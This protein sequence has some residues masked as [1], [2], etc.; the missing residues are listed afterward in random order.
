MSLRVKKNHQLT[1]SIHQLINLQFNQSINQ[2]INLNTFRT[3]VSKVNCGT[4]PRVDDSTNIQKKNLKSWR[5]G[6]TLSLSSL[7]FFYFFPLLFHCISLVPA[8]LF[9]AALERRQLRHWQRT[10]AA[11]TITKTGPAAWMVAEPLRQQYQ[12]RKCFLFF[13]KVFSV[14]ESA[15]LGSQGCSWDIAGPQ[16]VAQHPVWLVFLRLLIWQLFFWPW[17]LV[18][19]LLNLGGAWWEVR[20]GCLVRLCPVNKTP[21]HLKKILRSWNR[22]GKEMHRPQHQTHNEASRNHDATTFYF[23]IFLS[24]LCLHCCRS[25]FW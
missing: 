14:Y 10:V 5:H 12:L 24:V 9:A 6:R 2:S 15:R 4:S 8:R 22:E 20:Q 13:Q 17:S 1:Q 7:C 19:S 18:S 11:E 16:G 3:D 21:P 23:A 25:F